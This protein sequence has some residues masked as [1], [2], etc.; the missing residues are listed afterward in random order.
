MPSKLLKSSV[1]AVAAMTSLLGVGAH[2]SVVSSPTIVAYPENINHR[3]IVSGKGSDIT[4]HVE[5]LIPN[6]TGMPGWT[7]TW[8]DPATWTATLSAPAG[9]KFLFTPAVGYGTSMRVDVDMNW[10]I[11]T[12]ISD[13][14]VYFGSTS[15]QL[16]DFAGTAPTVFGSSSY[17]GINQYGVAARLTLTATEAFS[18]TSITFTTS[19]AQ[20]M[21]R[22]SPI[23]YAVH[24]NPITA[25]ITG[26]GSLP[27]TTLMSI[28]P[29]P[30][31]ASAALVCAG[32]AVLATGRRRKT[33]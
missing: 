13:Y 28:V 9:Y 20:S 5:D 32:I 3:Y 29:I 24:A 21:Q 4:T 8:V 2:A 17:A 31:P 15:F 1:I 33:A 19:P 10:Q 7:V 22:T 25:Q 14:T 30:E 18:F 11:S 6:G 26:T 12:P 23:T 16:T 27:D